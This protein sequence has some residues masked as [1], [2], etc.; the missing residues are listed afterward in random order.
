[1]P[2]RKKTLGWWSPD[3][4]GVIPLDGLIVSRSLRRSCRRYEV[5]FNTRFRRCDG[6]VRRPEPAARL[7]HAAVRRRVRG[8]APSRMGAQRRDVPR[9][10]ARRRPV[11]GED[12]R[13][14]RR[15]V[16]VQRCHRC[17]EGRVG[18]A[19]R[20]ARRT[21]ARRC[22]TCNGRPRISCRSVPSTCP[23]RST[24]SCS[25]TR[26]PTGREISESHRCCGAGEFPHRHRRPTA[27]P[28]VRRRTSTPP[29]DSA[30]LE[31]SA[32]S[33]RTVRL[34]SSERSV[35]DLRRS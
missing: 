2:V 6:T 21:R 31:S 4:R 1:M 8:A 17:L 7:D 9:R 33:F 27:V 29:I 3:P 23:A 32:E 35:V 22:S 24:W 14:V 25:P 16:D 12:R 11:R 13:A 30:R 20:L 15:R 26:S 18:V 10:Q 34:N 5:R 19:G 28:K